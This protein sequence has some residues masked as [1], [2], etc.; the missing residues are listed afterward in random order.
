MKKLGLGLLFALSLAAM[1][2][3]EQAKVEAVKPTRKA[4]GTVFYVYSDASSRLNHWCPAGWA[5]DYGDL[6]YAQNWST[7][8]AKGKTCIRVS[9]S[10]ERKQGAGWAGIFYQNPCNNWATMK[11]AGYDL[12]GFTS[13]KFYARGEKGGELVD[14]FMIGGITDAT[15][16]GDSDSE[17]TEPI[18]L[19]KDW[20]EYTIPLKGRDLSHLISGFSFFFNSEM[21]PNGIV[22]FIDEVRFEK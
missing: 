6:K 12:T 5:G 22:I 19:T 21:N 18:E 1:V 17:Y 3:G 14:K 15:E 9:Y 11:N 16:Q 7:N 8:T 4:E 2:W 13:L 20:K 10:A